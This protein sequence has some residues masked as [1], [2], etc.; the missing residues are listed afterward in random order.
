MST[1][2]QEDVEDHYEMGEELGSGES[3]GRAGE[4]GSFSQ[5]GPHLSQLF[6]ILVG[7]SRG[8]FFQGGS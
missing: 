7:K 8:F 1:F 4:S 2:R 6:H 5:L 3:V